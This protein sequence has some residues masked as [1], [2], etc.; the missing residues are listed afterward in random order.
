MPTPTPLDAK[1]RDAATQ[2]LARV[3]VPLTFTARSG[4]SYDPSTG[5]AVPGSTTYALPASPPLD[6]DVRYLGQ[7]NG[8]GDTIQAGDVKI[9]LAGVDA[10]AA[11]YAPQVGD[12][13]AINGAEWRCVGIKQQWSGALVAAYEMQ[14]RKG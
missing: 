6:Y 5:V 1:L 2:A 9:I 12:L 4:G 14:F 3:G 11:G 8:S 13:V 10:D 7:S